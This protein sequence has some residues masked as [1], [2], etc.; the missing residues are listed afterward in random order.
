VE[1]GGSRVDDDEED[2]KSNCPRDAAAV[3]LADV[4]IVECMPK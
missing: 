3:Q 1:E 4:H 2:G